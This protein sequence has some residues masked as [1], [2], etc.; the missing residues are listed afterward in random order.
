MVKQYRICWENNNGTNGEGPWRDDNGNSDVWIKE[1][2]KCEG[3]A[4][5]WAE[6]REN[7]SEEL[8][9]LTE[10]QLKTLYNG[11]REKML[12]FTWVKTCA[13]SYWA[14]ATRP[15][16]LYALA[17]EIAGVDSMPD[18]DII[19]TVFGAGWFEDIS[20]VCKSEYYFWKLAHEWCSAMA[21]SE[22]RKPAARCISEVRNSNTRMMVDRLA[23]I[24]NRMT[25]QQICQFTHI[26]IILW[27]YDSADW[28]INP[29]W[30]YDRELAKVAE[31]GDE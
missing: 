12:E 4:R 6:W 13:V 11:T 18:A 2:N 15:Q 3:V 25:P 26:G 9:M 22:E 28:V 20:T 31:V 23:A 1:S 21:G 17:K 16:W 14:N 7:P 27:D 10:S 24:E 30:F 8:G 29:L 19:P 5:S